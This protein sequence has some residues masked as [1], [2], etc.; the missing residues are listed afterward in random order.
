MREFHRTPS[1]RIERRG[2][3][4]SRR[5]QLIFSHNPFFGNHNSRK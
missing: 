5:K 1:T 3:R 2:G 4:Q